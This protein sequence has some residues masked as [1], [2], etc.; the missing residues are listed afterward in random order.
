[1]EPVNTPTP[2]TPRVASEDTGKCDVICSEHIKA[3][4]SNNYESGS[5]QQCCPIRGK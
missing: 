1:M 2:T 5:I 3:N 4:S